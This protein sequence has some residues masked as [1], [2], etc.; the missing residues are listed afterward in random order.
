MMPTFPLIMKMAVGRDDKGQTE[1]YRVY[2]GGGVVTVK[3]KRG[4]QVNKNAILGGNGTIYVA[5]ELAGSTEEFVLLPRAAF[6]QMVNGN[7]KLAKPTG[8]AAG[9]K[10]GKK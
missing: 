3:N 4:E 5:N 2:E 6:E 7:A 8:P 10:K 1:N 9:G